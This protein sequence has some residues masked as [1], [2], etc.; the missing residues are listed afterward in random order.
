[1][2][3]GLKCLEL[4]VCA[5]K[6]RTSTLLKLTTSSKSA[7]RASPGWTSNSGIETGRTHGRFNP[8]TSR[9]HPVVPPRSVVVVLVDEDSVNPPHR[10]RL[11]VDTLVGGV[12]AA[13]LFLGGGE[14]SVVTGP[15]SV[16]RLPAY[17]LPAP[18]NLS[19]AE[20]L[21]RTLSL[22]LKADTFRLI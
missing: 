9:A 6:R 10:L 22:A 20:D 15:R 2:D 17:C 21:A 8:S 14:C 5:Y 12:Q 7:K 4:A 3:D 1:M 18:P 19:R 16:M 11:D 13:D